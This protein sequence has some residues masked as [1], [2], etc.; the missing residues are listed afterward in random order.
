MRRR[1]KRRKRYFV[2]F[3]KKNHSRTTPPPHSPLD[4]PKDLTYLGLKLD[5]QMTMQP[6]TI[7]TRQKIKLAYQTVS[8]IA[9]SLKHEPCP[10][11]RHMD[12]PTHPVPRTAVTRPLTSNPKPQ[13]QPIPLGVTFLNAVS[14]LKA[15][16]SELSKCH[17]KWD[18]LY[19]LNTS[20]VQHELYDYIDIYRHI[21]LYMDTNRHRYI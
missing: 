9:R 10:P 6:A 1:R 19:L 5:L 4:E 7:H 21:C 14:K 12:N 18:W 17:R 3:K 11:T 2:I 13:I 8:A 16:S 20:L 15:R